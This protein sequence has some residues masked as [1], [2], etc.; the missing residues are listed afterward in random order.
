MDLTPVASPTDPVVVESQ[1]TD[2]L[3]EDPLVVDPA[4]NVPSSSS[5]VGNEE[6]VKSANE[7]ALATQT[8]VIELENQKARVYNY[9]A[10]LNVQTKIKK[11]K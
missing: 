11:Q 4:A 3:I 1:S 5:R 9:A 2:I 10:Q 8:E 7:D 6:L